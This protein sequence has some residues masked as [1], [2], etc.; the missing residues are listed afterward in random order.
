MTPQEQIADLA[1]AT[2]PLTVTGMTALGYDI[3]EW[4]LL[5]T[6]IYTVLQIALV[7]R[8]LMVSRRETDITCVKDCQNRMRL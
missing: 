3:S 8:R 5:A 1:K 7:V 6:L 2:P 4:V